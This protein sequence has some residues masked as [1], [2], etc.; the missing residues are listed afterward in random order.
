MNSRWKNDGVA[1]LW[2]AFERIRLNQTVDQ[3]TGIL[4][5]APVQWMGNAIC[6]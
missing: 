5:Y 2:F 6:D 4:T 3:V 1:V